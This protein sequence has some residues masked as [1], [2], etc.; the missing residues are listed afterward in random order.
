MCLVFAGRLWS[1][2][3]NPVSSQINSSSN[4]FLSANSSNR[5]RWW[6]ES[7]QAFTH[8]PLGGTGAGTFELTDRRLRRSPIVTTEPHNV[9][10]QFLDG[11]G[12]R[13]L[14]ALPA[15]RGAVP[16]SASF[17]RGGGRTGAER[18]AATA[19]GLGVV[20]FLLHLVVDMDWN[21]VATCG[22]LL[23]VAGLLAGRGAP[24]RRAACA[25]AVRSSPLGVVLFA[26][27][28]LLLARRA[29]ARAAAAR[30]PR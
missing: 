15:R 6:D 18:A 10:L 28:R 4:R 1:D 27:A 24:A 2:F 30:R 16:C 25:R 9:P 11:D 19:L 26:L 13:R 29:V 17:A 3:T 8:H 21:Y 22:P 14:P 23:L 12:H 7:W 5:W 20:V